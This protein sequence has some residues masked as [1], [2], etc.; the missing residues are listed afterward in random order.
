MTFA[1]EL[2]AHWLERHA[3]AVP[4]G[5]KDRRDDEST[6]QE[7]ALEALAERINAARSVV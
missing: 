6:A 4:D 7:A 1:P 5:R 2:A 3:E